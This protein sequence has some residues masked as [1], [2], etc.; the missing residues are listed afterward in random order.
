MQKSPLILNFKEG[1][2]KRNFMD[3]KPRA[4][5]GPSASTTKAITDAAVSTAVVDAKRIKRPVELVDQEERTRMRRLAWAERARKA[6]SEAI[7]AAKKGEKH[8]YLRS[9]GSTNIDKLLLDFAP[10]SYRSTSL[11]G[12]ASEPLARR[13]RD[14]FVYWDKCERGEVKYD[15]HTYYD[16]RN[17]AYLHMEDFV[18]PKADKVSEEP[19]AA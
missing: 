4:E 6:Q 9:D 7:A 13:T 2:E 10:P 14:E 8:K 5:M 18:R 15:R 16:S 19:I 17:D 12:G 11:D 3:K 1:R